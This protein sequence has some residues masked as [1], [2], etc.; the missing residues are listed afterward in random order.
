MFD[1]QR[2]SNQYQVEFDA[3][4]MESHTLANL[5]EKNNYFGDDAGHF[6]YAHFGYLMACMGKVDQYSKLWKGPGRDDQTQRMI[7]FLA[8][9]V[10]PMP[11]FRRTHSVVVQMFRHSLMHTGEIRAI[12]DKDEGVGYTWRIHF[13]RL[14][15][16]LDHYSITEVDAVYQGLFKRLPLPAGCTL[17]GIRAINVSIPLL[18]DVLYGGVGRYMYQLKDSEDLQKNYLGSEREMSLQ[19]FRLREPSAG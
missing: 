2:A 6:R 19:H 14:P 11:E 18:L 4:R 13:G 16:G 5:F 15:D 12:F 8:E 17:K 1:F 9:F 7:D 3:L 10:Y